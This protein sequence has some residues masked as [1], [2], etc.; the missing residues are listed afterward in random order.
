MMDIWM[1]SSPTMNVL[2]IRC[3]KKY[4]FKRW[5]WPLYIYQRGGEKEKSVHEVTSYKNT[6]KKKILKSFNENMRKKIS[7]SQNVR[8][9]QFNLLIVLQARPDPVLS[10]NKKMI[11][12]ILRLAIYNPSFLYCCWKINRVFYLAQ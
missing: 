8:R 3:W 7:G 4:H 2:Y 11:I 6:E 9:D 5:V 10:R 12:W 1:I